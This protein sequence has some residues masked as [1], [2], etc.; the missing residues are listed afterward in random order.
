MLSYKP[1]KRG[2]RR[3]NNVGAIVA[4]TGSADRFRRRSPPVNTV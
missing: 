3:R 1:F 2:D 4:P